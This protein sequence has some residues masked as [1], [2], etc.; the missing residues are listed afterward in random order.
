MPADQEK[1]R[2][3]LQDLLR[4][5]FQ[6]DAADLDFGVYRILNQR[7]DEIERFIEEDLIQ[8]V[9][10][11]LEA[12]T[13]H[14]RIEIEDEIERKRQALVDS[15][16][17]Q[18][19]T[20]DGD[21]RDDLRETPVAQDYL[22]A[23][24]KR[25][26]IQA[27]EETEAR[28]FNDLYR[29]FS[30]YYEDGDFHSKR[31]YSSKGPKFYI[32]YNGEE[33][34]L[35]WANHDQYFIKTSERFTTYRFEAKDYTVEFRIQEAQTPQDNAKGE[36]RHF[37]LA[38]T[39]PVTHDPGTQELTI[40][41]EYRPLSEDEEEAFV[42]TYNEA[43]GESYKSFSRKKQTI[44][45]KALE[46]EIL[47]QLDAKPLRSALLEAEDDQDP[48]LLRHLKRYTASNTMDYFIHQNLGD[49]LRL[50]LDFFIKNEIVDLDQLLRTEEDIE[51]ANAVRGR[52]VR[53]IAERIIDFVEQI[54][55]FQKRLFE[56][57]KFV[58]ET[59][60]MVTLD[61]V[62]QSL[63]EDILTNSD[64]IRQWKD[65][66][67]FSEWR[68]DLHWGGEFDRALLDSYPHLMIDTAF[69]GKRFKQRLLESFDNLHEAVDGIA[70]QG[71]NFQALNLLSSKIEEEVDCVY[72]DPPYNTGNDEFLYKD[73]YR[74]SSWLSLLRTRVRLARQLLSSS[75]IFFISIDDNELERAK[76]L[77]NETFGEENFLAT[78]VWDRGH[79][80]QAGIFKEYHEYVLAY[81][82]E[83]SE[84]DNFKDVT[85]GDDIIAG[86]QKIVSEKNPA[87]EFTFPAGTRVDTNDRLEYDE[88]TR[89]GGREW[90]E[91]VEGPFLANNGELQESVTLR[92]GWTQLRQME[93]WFYGEED[94][95]DTKGQKVLEFYFNSSGKLKYRKERSRITPKTVREWGTQGNASAHLEALMGE[96]GIYDYPKPVGMMKEIAGWL[97]KE[98]SRTTYLDF[99]AGSGT[100]GEGI[101]QVNREDGEDRRYILVEMGEYFD[102]LLRPRLQ[103]SVFSSEWSDGVPQVADGRSHVLKY[104]RLESYEDSLSNLS[105]EREG[106]PQTS[107]VQEFERK[108][109]GYV[110]KQPAENA[111]LLSDE[112]FED[113]FNYDLEIR[114]TA[115]RSPE[116]CN[117]DLI[118][119]FHYLLGIEIDT[120][121]RREHQGRGY[122]ITR[123]EAPTSSGMENVRTV[124][125]RTTDL[126]L[127]EEARWFQEEFG[128]DTIDRIYVNGESFIKKSEPIEVT[129]RERMEADPVVN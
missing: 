73:D 32:P 87:A 110:L 126:D 16:G 45:P 119:T 116:R 128:E 4:E 120:F 125:R 31:R 80:Q 55:D 66:Y 95:Y 118:E 38:G 84:V 69:F 105:I 121:S 19:L 78:L 79:S 15:L 46:S 62:P 33:V 127:E 25:D 102:D 10:E 37:V 22:E 3:R 13:E 107:L 129:F 111:S 124:W 89:F 106:D 103:K 49:F 28:V 123:G 17:E 99:F 5:L 67:S 20:V 109:P 68:E 34:K 54:E 122:V 117:I 50:E 114:P 98:G 48:P 64:Q 18:A 72:I 52:V 93:E 56:K 57:K 42:E 14:D 104:Q 85:G 100:L 83:K 41:F 92:A 90:T 39:T 9:N 59:E 24:E 29:F 12:F 70:L 75:G 2:E 81:A 40:P 94:V 47:S 91:V 74:H 108:N 7:R 77:L 76:A 58:T 21:V 71:E 44:V 88:G 36:E 1:N 23:L 113:P 115:G 63:Y 53:E 6:F 26:E 60:Y 11:G 86:A 30:R 65:V 51:T 97:T 96:D 43:T 101:L 35:H 61:H 112:A 27:S 82:K 8:A